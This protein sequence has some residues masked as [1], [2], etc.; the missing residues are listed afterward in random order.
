MT[1]SGF[2]PGLF[3]PFLAGVH[4]VADGDMALLDLAARDAG[5]RA[6]AIDLEHCTGKPVLLLRMATALEVPPGSGRNWD[7]LSDLLR[8]LGWLPAPQGHA[9]LLSS[10]G[11]LRDAAPGD[12]ETLLSI[13]HE[14][15]ASWAEAGR[16]FWAFI[17]L[18]DDEFDLRGE[19]CPSDPGAQ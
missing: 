15:A 5:L 18:P 19:P 16:P 6:T 1:E 7:A 3:D 17:G 2:D 9:L 13:L 14:A 12:Y 10:A 8:D 4:R 11:D